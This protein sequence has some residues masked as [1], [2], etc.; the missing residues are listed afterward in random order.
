MLL[1]IVLN[2]EL[3]RVFISISSLNTCYGLHVTSPYLSCLVKY[4]N[5]YTAYQSTTKVCSVKYPVHSTKFINQH[6][7]QHYTLFA[8]Q[9]FSKIQIQNN[10]L[11]H[12]NS[13]QIYFTNH[14][15]INISLGRAPKL[16]RN[17]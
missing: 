10:Q 3:L 17:L 15:S 16:I 14:Q 8:N 7:Q 13:V 6:I 12:N 2:C 11:Q 4:S 1:F 9:H 5:I